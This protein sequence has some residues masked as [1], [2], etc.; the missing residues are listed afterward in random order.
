VNPET[1]LRD[2]DPIA[3]LKSLYGHAD[4]GIH[5]EVID[6]GQIALGDAIELLPE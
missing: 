2:A 4:L 6:G 3:E 1:G 5:A